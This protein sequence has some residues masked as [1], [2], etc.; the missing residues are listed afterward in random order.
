MGLPTN[1][2]ATEIKVRSLT[3][4]QLAAQIRQI[5]Y[6]RRALDKATADAV[7]EEAARRLTW[8]DAYENHAH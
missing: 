8:R 3:N 4:D 5:R 7:L 2:T 1:G 6:S